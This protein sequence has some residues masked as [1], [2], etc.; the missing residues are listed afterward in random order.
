MILCF[1]INNSIIIFTNFA[2]LLFI[3]TFVS[4]K[5]ELKV[6]CLIGI[7]YKRFVLFSFCFSVEKKYIEHTVELKRQYEPLK[8][9][10]T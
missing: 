4:F 10:L 7:I 3:L 9:P 1:Y 6:T 5:K 2:S 8:V